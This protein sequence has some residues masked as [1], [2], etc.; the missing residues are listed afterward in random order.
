MEREIN[1]LADPDSKS[2]PVSL[3]E[4][5]KTAGGR[6]RGGIKRGQK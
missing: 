2:R 5:L 3:A 6:K 1:I 4:Y